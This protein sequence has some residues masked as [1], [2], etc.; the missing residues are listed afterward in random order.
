MKFAAG[1]V[2]GTA[3]GWLLLVAVSTG[4]VMPAVMSALTV[5][6]STRRLV[7]RL[8]VAAWVLWKVDMVCCSCL[9]G[10]RRAAWGRR[11]VSSSWVHFGARW[12]PPACAWVN[13]CV[14]R[15]LAW[16]VRSP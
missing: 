16:L 14:L 8:R 11:N 2:C 10:P 7:R 9:G 4:T 13:A 5:I 15:L 6:A 1:A 3:R 12:L